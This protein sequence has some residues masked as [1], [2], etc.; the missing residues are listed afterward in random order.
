MGWLQS[1]HDNIEGY[2]RLSDIDPPAFKLFEK[3][4]KN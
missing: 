4:D 3:L 1:P 2:R